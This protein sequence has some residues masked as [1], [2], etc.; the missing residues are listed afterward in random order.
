MGVLL[1]EFSYLKTSYQFE[2]RGMGSINSQWESLVPSSK[3]LFSKVTS[4]GQPR[5]KESRF[6]GP[7]GNDPKAEVVS[8]H[9]YQPQQNRRTNMNQEK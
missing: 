3:R 4:A 2:A 7:W 6:A 1:G 8:V 5:A 9:S